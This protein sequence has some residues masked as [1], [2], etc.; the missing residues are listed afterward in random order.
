MRAL[1]FDD[2]L[3]FT[4][5]QPLPTPDPDEALIRV[6]LA[7]ICH[8]DLELTH[9]Y[10]GFR[11][12]LGHEFVGE[13]A[14]GNALWA[15]GQ[16]VV[17]EINVACQRC[18]LCAEGVPSQCRQ[19]RVLGLMD[20]HGTFADFTA[21]PFV[22]LHAVPDSIPDEH[23]V[24]AEPL[25]A[26]L[27]VPEVAAIRPSQRVVLIGA[28]KLGLLIAH[29]LQHL[30]C[31]LAVVVRSQRP[32]DLLHQWRIPTIDLRDAD[33]TALRQSAHVVVDSTGNAAGFAM[34]LDVVRPRGT[35]VLKSTYAGLPSADLSRV[36]VDEIKVVGS[37][38]GPFDAALRMIAAGRIDLGPMID[39]LYPLDEALPAFDHAARAGV[40][41]VL[42]RT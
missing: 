23:A 25:A 2:Q 29:V 13:I 42:L 8:T 14:Q 26:A 1:R 20:Y 4:T 28:G 17:G 36:V 15:V 6:R 40:L 22:N 39:G 37:R 7:G 9:G 34:A 18:D 24:F 19:R 41:K 27:Q 32:L 31:D 10:K 5:T 35:V 38:C 12:V 3:H 30:G 16:R 11:G 21:L 33:L